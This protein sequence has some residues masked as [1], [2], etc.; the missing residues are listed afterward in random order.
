MFI[1][2]PAIHKNDFIRWINDILIL[3]EGVYSGTTEE[4]WVDDFG[5]A[6]LTTEIIL[7]IQI[8]PKVVDKAA[9]NLLPKAESLFQI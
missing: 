5:F 2:R 9:L 8:V 6:I 1:D 7:K 3:L 4:I